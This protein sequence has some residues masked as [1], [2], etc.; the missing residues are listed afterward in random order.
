MAEKTTRDDDE[1]DDEK[2]EEG[3][4]EDVPASADIQRFGD[5]DG[6]LMTIAKAPPKK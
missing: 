6:S 5:E 1:D 3:N 2:D 4:E